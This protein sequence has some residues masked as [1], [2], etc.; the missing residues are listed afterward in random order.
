MRFRFPLGSNSE[1]FELDRNSQVAAWVKND[2][3]SFEILY[4]FKGAFLKYRPDY[5]VRLTNGRMLVLE[6]KG[7]ESQQDRTKREFLSEW[8][9]A[10]NAHGGFG[11]WACDVA[12]SPADLPGI[13]KKHN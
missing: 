2:H 12:F 6:V 3:W 10:V 4:L 7:Q 9:K 13:L 5:L 11:A 1:A 8:V